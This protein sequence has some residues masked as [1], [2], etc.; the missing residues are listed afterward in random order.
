MS[1]TSN[2]ARP[3]QEGEARLSQRVRIVSQPGSAP[4][5]KLMQR[6]DHDPSRPPAAGSQ[7]EKRSKQP[8]A[9]AGPGPSHLR[10]TIPAGP[11]PVENSRR[12]PDPADAGPNSGSQK[13]AEADQQTSRSTVAGWLCR[14]RPIARPQLPLHTCRQGLRAD[15]FRS[16]R[17][18]HCQAVLGSSMADDR[19][20]HCVHH[21]D[22]AGSLRHRVA[23][24]VIQTAPPLLGAVV[25]LRSTRNSSIPSTTNEQLSGIQ[26]RGS[27]AAAG[28]TGGSQPGAKSE[29]RQQPGGPR[30]SASDPVAS[31]LRPLQTNGTLMS[32]AIGVPGSGRGPAGCLAHSTGLVGV[33]PEASK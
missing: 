11:G 1:R 13:Q 31:Q 8:G 5:N 3:G 4:G 25:I 18:G 2:C 10:F 15:A 26:L 9:P 16:M 22:L 24:H 27:A 28:P 21:G 29:A 17:L 30:R 7:Q 6:A 33:L 19:Q 12:K 32:G 20:A 14:P 23:E